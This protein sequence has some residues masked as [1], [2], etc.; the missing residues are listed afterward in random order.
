[1]INKNLSDSEIVFKSGKIV[2]IKTY[3]YLYPH[4]YNLSVDI[5]NC[6]IVIGNSKYY[7]SRVSIKVESVPLLTSIRVWTFWPRKVKV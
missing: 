1:M 3:K 2:V 5:N 7:V 6:D 4:T